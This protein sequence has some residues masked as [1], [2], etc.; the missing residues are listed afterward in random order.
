MKTKR[1]LNVHFSNKNYEVLDN[2]DQQPGQGEMILM[3]MLK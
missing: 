2:R 3:Y 1:L